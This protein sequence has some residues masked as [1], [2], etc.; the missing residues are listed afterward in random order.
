[1]APRRGPE[2]A[3]GGRQAAADRGGACRRGAAAAAG[4]R[5]EPG[6]GLPEEAF[7][8]GS[9][10]L[11]GS[12]EHPAPPRRQPVTP[13]KGFGARSVFSL[14]DRA[15]RR[16]RPPGLPPLRELLSASLGA[17]AA[18]PPAP[19][20]RGRGSRRRGRGRI[21]EPCGDPQER[22]QVR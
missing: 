10:S 17:P 3:G 14:T 16:Y 8:D 9:G 21:A 2:G 11:Y 20:S 12:V 6:A 15:S 7:E 18:P 22:L 13:A 4:V 19:P 5:G 1:M